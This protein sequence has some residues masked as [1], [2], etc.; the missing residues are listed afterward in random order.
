M[1]LFQP[2]LKSHHNSRVEI[3]EDR[4]LNSNNVE[5]FSELT[6][7]DGLGRQNRCT[8]SEERTQDEI[9]RRRSKLFLRFRDDKTRNSFFKKKF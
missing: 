8:E 5:N 2:N 3:S 4:T 6:L 7:I 9:V 1:K